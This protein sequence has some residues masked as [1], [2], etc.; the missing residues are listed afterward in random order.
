MADRADVTPKLGHTRARGT[1]LIDLLL[2]APDPQTAVLAIEAVDGPSRW[3]SGRR[4]RRPTPGRGR[5][6]GG[7]GEARFPL[8]P[9]AAAG[10]SIG[11][12]RL[13]SRSSNVDDDLDRRTD[14]PCGLEVAIVPC[15]S[16]DESPSTPSDLR[17]PAAFGRER[18]MP[19][20]VRPLRRYHASDPMQYADRSRTGHPLDVQAFRTRRVGPQRTGR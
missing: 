15:L 20:I 19:L 16:R 3:P 4:V 9:A 8:L 17:K 13:R 12:R 6:S 5:S 14:L 2:L 18:A 1:Q 10:P 11:A 7:V